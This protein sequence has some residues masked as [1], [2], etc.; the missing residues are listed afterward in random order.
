LTF[1]KKRRLIVWSEAAQA[2]G[3]RA[4]EAY[5][6]FYDVIRSMEWLLERQ[7]DTAFAEQQGDGPYWLLTSDGYPFADGGD[8]P[9]VTLIYYFDDTTV[10]FWGMR[11]M[12]PPPI[13][14]I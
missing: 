8:L 13:E 10:T 14:L 2:E 7:P 11:V 12:P 4:A 1:R 5:E 9:E 6:R 3:L